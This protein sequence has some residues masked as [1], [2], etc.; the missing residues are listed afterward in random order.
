MN[1]LFIQFQANA[2]V[3]QAEKMWA[4]TRQTRQES[5]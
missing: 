5:V 2:F 1:E 4:H 3:T